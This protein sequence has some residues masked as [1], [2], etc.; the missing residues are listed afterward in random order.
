MQAKRG[1]SLQNA[2]RLIVVCAEHPKITWDMSIEKS[3]MKCGF[4]CMHSLEA[5]CLA[6]EQRCVMYTEYKFVLI[7]S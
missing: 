7:T 1:N 5:M 4:T 2:C 6:I 3:R